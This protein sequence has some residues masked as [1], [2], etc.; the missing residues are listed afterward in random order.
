MGSTEGSTHFSWPCPGS[1]GQLDLQLIH[2]SCTMVATLAGLSL[3]GGKTWS[4]ILTASSGM[5]S[6]CS[7]VIDGRTGRVRAC[8]A[9]IPTVLPL[10]PKMRFIDSITVPRAGRLPEAFCRHWTQTDA[11]VYLARKGHTFVEFLACPMEDP[12]SVPPGKMFLDRDVFVGPDPPSETLIK[13][14]MEEVERHVRAILERLSLPTHCLTFVVATRHGYCAGH[15]QHKLSFRPFIQGMCIR[16]TDIP[17]I[18][19]AVGQAGFWDMSVYKQSEQLLATILGC[20]GRLAGVQDSRVLLPQPGHEDPLLYIVQSVDDSWPFLDLPVPSPTTQAPPAKEAQTPSCSSSTAGAGPLC[21]GDQ[22]FVKALLRCMGTRCSDD[23]SV[24]INVGLVVKGVGTGL[25][26]AMR[27]LF[28]QDWLEFSRRGTKFGG[29]LAARKTWEGL[30]ARAVGGAGSCGIGTLCHHAR[31]SDVDGYR[32]ACADRA[33]AG[34]PTRTGPD[35]DTDKDK[36]KRG[37]KRP[38]AVASIMPAPSSQS[39][40]HTSVNASSRIIAAIGKL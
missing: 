24:W 7:H 22:A 15:K 6:P 32:R 10:E 4:E 5:S 26:A 40:K 21:E 18:I 31:E 36:A 34:P 38:R 33:L 27:D 11:R 16:Y 9:H 13:T 12:R 20:K 39:F 17:Q 1:S 25:G 30:R 8:E 37:V 29:D 28:Y 23:R 2:G 35:K 19:Q 3:T 14:H